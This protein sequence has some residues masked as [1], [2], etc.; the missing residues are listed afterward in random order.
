MLLKFS[1]CYLIENQLKIFFTCI[2]RIC[3]CLKIKNLHCLGVFFRSFYSP[4]KIAEIKVISNLGK[5]FWSLL[6][7]LQR[8][9]Q[10]KIQI[11]LANAFKNKF[12][13]ILN[14]VKTC[15]LK[16][17]LMVRKSIFFLFAKIMNSKKSVQ[18]NRRQ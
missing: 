14:Y 12:I 2:F 8:V 13:S 17:F 5:V 6:N 16:R 9:H 1:D 3:R 18:R 10:H 11:L 7:T 15:C 4:I